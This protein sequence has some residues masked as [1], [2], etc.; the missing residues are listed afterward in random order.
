MNFSKFQRTGTTTV[1]VASVLVIFSACSAEKERGVNDI[2]NDQVAAMIGPSKA[3]LLL[4]VRSA[5]EFEGGHIPGSV[6]IPHDQL[7]SRIG[8]IAMHRE[9]GVIVYCER[10]G[11]AAKAA[12]I[13]QDEGFA[14]IQ[15]MEGDM[16]G[17]RMAG[18]PT[19]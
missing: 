14:S 5:R 7:A 19:E 6:N 1:L 2:G 4:D 16:T 12:A 17:W 18:L 9:R 3:P 10:G 15:H 8:E 13:L 11:R